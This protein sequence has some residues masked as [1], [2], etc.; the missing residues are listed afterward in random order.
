MKAEPSDQLR[1]PQCSDSARGRLREQQRRG[2]DLGDTSEGGRIVQGRGQGR[3]N[4][5]MF[6]SA[7]SPSI[8][9][10][11]LLAKMAR[12]AAN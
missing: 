4:S 8:Y 10:F 9:P 5:Q 11:G 6:G 12:V 1:P 7:N 2:R 3:S